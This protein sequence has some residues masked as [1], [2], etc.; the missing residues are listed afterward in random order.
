M[1][2]VIEN[3]I[4]TALVDGEVTENKKFIILNKAKSHIINLSA[5]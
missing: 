3:F 5:F 1:L 4:A 2:P